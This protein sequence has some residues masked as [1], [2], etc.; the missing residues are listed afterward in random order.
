MVNREECRSDYDAANYVEQARIAALQRAQLCHRSALM[1]RQMREHN[2][3]IRREA[4]IDRIV[5]W[6]VVWA[7]IATA[8]AFYLK[9]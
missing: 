8:L 2:A 9:G 3:Q 5:L 1:A 4:R 7:L 6:V